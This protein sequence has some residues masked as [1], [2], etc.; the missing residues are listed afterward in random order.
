MER[1]ARRFALVG[2]LAATLALTPI[3]GSAHGGS[4]PRGGG[5]GGHGPRQQ[6][7]D[8][9]G[10][11]TSLDLAGGA[12]VLEGRSG[13][14]V[15]VALTAA[16]TITSGE[17]GD[18]ITLE[19]GQSVQ[20]EGI[21]DRSTDT[22]TA[23]AITLNDYIV[24]DDARARGTVASVDAAA[25]SFVLTV[26]ALECGVGIEPTGDTITVVT[27]ADTAF[28]RGR[29]RTGSFADVVAGN[30]AEVKGSFDTTTQT[31][32]AEVVTLR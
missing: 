24:I 10:T 2:A 3:M 28:V 19:D 18:P 13:R 6:T 14:T 31:L 7:V 1:I 15:T 4:S 17:T 5:R 30:T 21:Y 11:V 27:N 22:I 29:R 25:A 8:L 12:F 9:V 26:D 16:T 32:T 23:T 20:V